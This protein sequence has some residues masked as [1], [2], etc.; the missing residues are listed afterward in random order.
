[1][2]SQDL[3]LFEFELKRNQAI[4]LL[5]SISSLQIQYLG[6]LVYEQEQ[7]N[8]TKGNCKGDS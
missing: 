4:S 2:R 3:L 6:G 8:E 5:R 1:M 7:R